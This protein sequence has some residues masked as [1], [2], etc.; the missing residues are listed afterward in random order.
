MNRVVITGLGVVTSLGQNVEE[1]WREIAYGR[2]GVSPLFLFDASS[3][4]VRIASQIKDFNPIGVISKKETLRMDR[5][6]QLALVAATEA[7]KKA[8]LKE[9]GEDVGVVV[10]SGVGGLESIL[11]E[12]AVLMERGP[13]KVS[14]FLVP[15]MIA[16]SACAQIAI[17]FRANGPSLAP[18]TACASSLHALG[19][20][21]QL[22]KW[23]EARIIISGGAEAPITPLALAGFS[24]MGAL[25]RRNDEPEK[26][27]RPFDL[28]RD[29]FVMG[30]GAGI[31]I[32]E[33]LESAQER[34]AHIY[35]EILSFA[36]STD[37]F[38]I[39]APEP[40]GHAVAQMIRRALAEAS[41]LPQEIDY[42]NAH[43]TSTLLNDRIETKV[44]KEV[45]S[46]HAPRLLVSSTK[47][48]IGHLLGAAGAVETIAS[49]LSLERGIVPPTINLE[50]PDPE[51][52]LNYV[53]NSAFKKNVRKIMKLSYGF[54]GHNACLILGKFD[55]GRS[56]TET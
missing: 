4:P 15:M 46:D 43:G 52:D 28:F 13:D 40:N 5:F 22:I 9:G 17:R 27:S 47:S 31:L 30:E 50:N 7:W 56:L 42:I 19:E 25:S 11:K 32:L 39:T 53:P 29:G 18:V 16:N 23:G 54:G 26:A 34:G 6:T 21:Y 10:G 3:L 38:H 36:A 14:P 51:C 48:M 44:L 12:E 1:F 45:F 35:A 33:S 49:I 55:Q 24:N 2:S 41:L 37:A 20:A 8:G